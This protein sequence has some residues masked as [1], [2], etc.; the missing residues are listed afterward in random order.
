VVAA[1]KKVRNNQLIKMKKLFFFIGVLL[2]AFSMQ[3]QKTIKDA[4]AELREAKNFHSITISDAFDV[5]LTQD[6]EEA[7]AVSANETRYRELITVE[8]KNG[9]LHVGLKKEGLRWMRGNK[10]LKAYISFRK[11]DKLD[12]RGASDIYIQGTMKAEDLKLNIS[13]ASN[14]KGRIESSNLVVDLSGASDITVT[15]HASKLDLE[16]SGASKFKGNNFSTDFCSAKASGASDIL[17]TVNKE[18]KANANGA[19]AVKIKGDGVITE[20]R[21]GGASKVTKI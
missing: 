21:A 19:S 9:V 13:G 5:F 20:L 2:L 11:L 10:Q 14:L 16:V 12:V 18:V 4:N 6:N 3:A 15:G 8:V 7:V 17:L 1:L